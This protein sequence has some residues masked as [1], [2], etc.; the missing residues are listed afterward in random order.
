[1][2]I[3][4]EH[5]SLYT[6]LFRGRDDVYARRWE[7]DTKSGWSPAYTF[8]WNEFN[9]HRAH[10]GVLKD[11]KNKTLLPLNERVIA[12]HLGGKE[13][14]GVYPILSDNTSYFI[15]ADFD[16]TT[17][18]DDAKRLVE[19]CADNGLLVYAEISRGGNGAHVWVFFAEAYPCWKSRK[20][21]LTLIAE[22]SP[23]SEFKKEDSFDRLFPNQDTILDGGFGNLIG[24]PLQGYKVTEKCTVFY[25]TKSDD[26]YADQWEF[27]KNI[28]RHSF[29]ELNSAYEKICCAATTQNVTSSV[30]GI[31]ISV[32][33]N[34]TI[35]RNELSKPVVN[36]IKENLNIFNKEYGMK[37]RLGKSTFSTERYFHLIEEVGDKAILPRGFIVPLTEFLNENSISYTLTQTKREFDDVSFSNSIELKAEQKNLVTQVLKNTNGILVA[38]PG[39]GKTIMALEIITRLTL[40]SIILVH[41]NQLLHQWVERIE[42]FLGIPKAHIGVISG[43]KKKVG[44][45]ITV[46]SLQSLARYKNFNEIRSMFGVI[47]IDECHHIPAK[48]Y[49]ETIRGFSGKYCYGLTATH[50]RRFDQHHIAEL[51]IGPIVAEMKTITGTESKTFDIEIIPSLLDLPFRYKNDHYEVLAKTIS[52]DT[53]RNRLIVNAVNNHLKQNRK[54]LLLTERKEHIEILALHLRSTTEIVTLSGDD[55]ALQRKLKHDQIV[56]GNFKVLIATGQL[57][58]EGLDVQGF[59]V[60]VLAFP[61]SFEGKLKQ[62]IGRLRGNGVKYIIDIRDSQIDFLERQFKKRIKVYEKEFGFSALP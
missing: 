29:S 46:A 27:L 24:A 1:M 23:Q 44:K 5:I 40:P 26:I 35:N 45:Q 9:A 58:G 14:I 47:I 18:K 33:G 36:F 41:R 62:Y 60:L 55:S 11:F 54:I 38:P 19:K 37:M 61:I 2:D 43:V 25:D 51:C 28:H 20:I 17:W 31:N 6:S 32:D 56:A 42:Q 50:E 21:M 22:V 15:A 57:F 13:T 8:D 12:A 59:D 16:E 39:S 34:I 49:R 10:G 7:K 52:F 53:A 30:S 48:T 4:P 3:N